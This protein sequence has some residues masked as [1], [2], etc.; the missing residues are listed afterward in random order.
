MHVPE[1][2]DVL[3]EHID[4]IPMPDSERERVILLLRLGA[5]LSLELTDEPDT[6]RQL[7]HPTVAM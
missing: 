6:L 2:A 1:H 5:D 4:P 7:L 3:P